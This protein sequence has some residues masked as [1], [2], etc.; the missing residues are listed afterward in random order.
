MLTGAGGVLRASAF[1][2]AAQLLIA[3]H[4]QYRSQMLVVSDGAQVDLANLVEGAVG[5]LQ[6]VAADRKPA[7]G[8]VAN[9]YVLADCR[10]RATV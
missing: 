9:S 7:S 8:V 10:D 1:W 3:D 6:A 2:P 4:R 5:K